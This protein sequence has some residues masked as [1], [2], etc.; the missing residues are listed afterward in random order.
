MEVS[1]LGFPMKDLCEEPQ[2]PI[3]LGPGAWVAQLVTQL[4]SAQ[5]GIPGSWGGDLYPVPSLL[6]GEPASPSLSPSTAPPA[7]ALS[8][9]H[10]N[11]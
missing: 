4:P 3:K 10:I 11:K 5:V 6:S 7:C 2:A 1:V 8:F 9:C